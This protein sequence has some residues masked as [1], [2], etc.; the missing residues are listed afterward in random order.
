VVYP[1]SAPENWQELLAQQF[2]PAFISPLH[3]KDFND[4]G[5]PKK[6]HYHVILMFDGKKS[7]EQVG[8]IFK[9]IGGVGTEIVKSIRGYSRYLCH[10]DNPEKA[11]Y[12]TSD[13]KS[14]C[15]ADYI[16]T[17]GLA[18]DKYNALG[19]MQDFCDQYNVVSFYALSKYAR[20]NR[21]DW[22]RI[23]CDCGAVFMREY[24]KSR[25]WSLENGAV[26]IVDPETG[27]VL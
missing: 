23:L 12:D 1:E 16:S 17:I 14:L 24:L 20:S 18:I 22:H 5:E 2:I 21:S 10:L 4:T 25:Q 11:Q 19:E 6:A 7:V 3:D 13:V 8:E 27:E 26:D 9:Q 15:G